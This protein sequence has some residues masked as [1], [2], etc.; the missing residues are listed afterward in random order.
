MAAAQVVTIDDLNS[1]YSIPEGHYNA[2]KENAC[3]AKGIKTCIGRFNI[4][5]Q[6][7]KTSEPWGMF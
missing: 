2:I 4:T 1:T 5:K 7:F 6:F 3:F